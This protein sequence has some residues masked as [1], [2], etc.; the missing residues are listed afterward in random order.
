MKKQH[1]KPKEWP[2]QVVLIFACIMKIWNCRSISALHK[3]TL[4][5]YA[6]LKK[7]DFNNPDPTISLDAVEN[8]FAIL[9]QVAEIKFACDEA[10]LTK[11]KQVIKDGMF[12]VRVSWCRLSDEKKEKIM[13][14]ADK[15][16]HRC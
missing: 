14:R 6:T 12:D 7:L 9:Y 4:L 3:D 15:A 8:I 11:L 5:P 10:R 1:S 16:S 2:R 13:K